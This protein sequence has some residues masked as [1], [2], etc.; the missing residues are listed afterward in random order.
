ML[1]VV[2]PVAAALLL[3]TVVGLP[4][5]LM[6]L[7]LYAALIYLSPVPVAMWIGEGILKAA[8]VGGRHHAVGGFLLGMALLLTFFLIPWLGG[9]LRLLVTLA[10]L[11]AILL[12]LVSWARRAPSPHP[13]PIVA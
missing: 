10:G 12:A 4:L 3:I 13:G 2:V 6:A 9:L 8:K 7:G 5:S 1:L 11:G